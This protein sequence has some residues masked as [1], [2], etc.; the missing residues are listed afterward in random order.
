MKP[1]INASR[2]TLNVSKS[3]PGIATQSFISACTPVVILKRRDPL[4]R[5][6]ALNVYS[7]IFVH[8]PSQ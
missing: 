1:L 7:H 5:N 6:Y 2:M 4:C 8:N 3:I